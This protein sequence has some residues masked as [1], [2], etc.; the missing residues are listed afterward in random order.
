MTNPRLSQQGFGSPSELCLLNRHVDLLQLKVAPVQQTTGS[1][2][3]S[4]TFQPFAPRTDADDQADVGIASRADN[5]EA[6]PRQ[7]SA[8][9]VAEIVLKAP[10][11]VQ[12]SAHWFIQRALD[13]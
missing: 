11:A 1:A 9:C 7:T 4:Y 8:P 5:L 3:G 12:R 13:G 10:E 2:L 6:D